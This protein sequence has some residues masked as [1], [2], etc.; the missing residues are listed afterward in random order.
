VKT[1]DIQ[2]YPSSTWAPMTKTNHVESATG[3]VPDFTGIDLAIDS[4]RNLYVV[5]DNNINGEIKIR[6]YPFG[7]TPGN[8]IQIVDT[9]PDTSVLYNPRIAINSDNR[10][11]VVYN[12]KKFPGGVDGVPDIVLNYAI[13][14]IP[15]M[16][17]PVRVNSSASVSTV[18]Q[19]PDIAIDKECGNIF[20]VYEDRRD[21][22]SYGEI[23]W[24]IMDDQFNIIQ[25]DERVN[26]KDL[27]YVLGDFDVHFGLSQNSNGFSII[28][29]WEQ[30]GED[31]WTSM[32]Y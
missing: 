26:T 18:K 32:A 20:I 5:W 30:T 31:T 8:S 23:Y 13:D 3:D 6:K 17:F 27:T 28:A 24:T 4:S 2:N 9:N 14:D 21:N 22:A 10:P 12:H 11:V 15:T 16:S 19:N 7:L 1:T 25:T 29:T